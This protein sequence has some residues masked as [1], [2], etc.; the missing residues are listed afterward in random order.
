MLDALKFSILLLWPM[1]AW[2]TS[3]TLG[4]S[5]AG[6]PMLAWVMVLILS[7]VSGL[8]ALLTRWREAEPTKPVLFAAS[9]M[10]GSLLSGVLTFLVAEYAEVPDFGEAALIAVA[11]FAGARLIDAAAVRLIDGVSKK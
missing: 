9:H 11:A 2:A 8:A 10:L 6:V 4:T 1:T 7:L 3:V 5:L